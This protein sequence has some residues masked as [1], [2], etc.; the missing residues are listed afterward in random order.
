MHSPRIKFKHRHY[1]NLSMYDWRTEYIESIK[2][3]PL[4]TS[5]EVKQLFAEMKNGNPDARQKI[6]NSN[7]RLAFYVAKEFHKKH[8]Y[9]L[10]YDLQDV[11]QEANIGLMKAVDRYDH[12]L[13]YT[14]ATYAYHWIL[15]SIERAMPHYNTGIYIPHRAYTLNAKMRSTESQLYTELGRYPTISELAE[16]LGISVVT[17]ETLKKI[18]L[19]I[20]I[21]FKFQTDFDD[22]ISLIEVLSA[23]DAFD[24]IDDIIT[25]EHLT[26]EISAYLN[27]R[28]ENSIIKDEERAIIKMHFGI[29]EERPMSF[30]D[31]ALIMPYTRQRAFQNFKNGMAKL[32]LICSNE[33]VPYELFSN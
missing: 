31:I 2:Q 1:S 33:E 20:S 27:Q 12:T 14:F 7:L 4:L 19:F 10:P 25:R 30:R 29:D 23:D 18:P 16:K 21:D 24:E 28:L 22:Y 8:I 26:P 17:V 6:I 13:G 9:S 5:E 11:V 15:Q 3:F 32:R